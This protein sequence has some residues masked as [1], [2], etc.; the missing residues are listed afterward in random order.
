MEKSGTHTGHRQRLRDRA[1]AEGLD[2]FEPHQVMELLLFYAIARQDVSEMAHMLIRRFGTVARVLHASREELM[3]ISGV[4]KRTAEWLITLGETVDAYCDLREEDRRCITN[5]RSAFQFCKEYRDKVQTPSAW[6]IC[7]T[8]SGSISMFSEICRSSQWGDAEVFRKSIC[9]I[10][11]G[12]TRR[13]IIALFTGEENPEPTRTDIEW[14]KAYSFLFGNMNMLLMDVIFVGT[15]SMLSMKQRGL[16]E[17]DQETKRQHWR[18]LERY[19]RENDE[20]DMPEL[21]F[22]DTDSGL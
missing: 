14:A 7:M 15:D 16:Y 10:L 4:G 13:V 9:E 17:N 2:A 12:N 3:E 1:A 5:F 11:T 6:H 18:I 19:L 20:A 21:D 8:P 22:P